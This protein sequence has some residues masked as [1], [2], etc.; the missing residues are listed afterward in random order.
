MKLRLGSLRAVPHDR[1]H[2]NA[3][4]RALSPG[5]HSM[6]RPLRTPPKRHGEHRST[7]PGPQRIPFIAIS[8]VYQR[9]LPNHRNS[10]RHLIGHAQIMTI[11]DPLSPI[12][13]VEQ[14]IRR[15]Y[16]RLGF[17]LPFAELRAHAVAA[18]APIN[19]SLMLAHL[20]ELNPSFF[21]TR[22]H[23]KQIQLGPRRAQQ[24]RR[25][26]ELLAELERALIHCMAAKKPL[27][28]PLANLLSEAL[29]C[30]DV[31]DA[32]A[33]R[34]VQEEGAAKRHCVRGGYLR[35]RDYRRVQRLT[36]RFLRTKAPAGRWRSKKH[37]AYTIAEHLGPLVTKH[38]LKI[39]PVEETLA[40]NV[41]KLMRRVPGAADA[42]ERHRRPHPSN[43]SSHHSR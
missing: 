36:L 17:R 26:A 38:D 15:R 25:T 18:V 41:L 29:G 7:D 34:H 42:F 16:E 11:L 39:S 14:E 19:S 37:A 4:I 22:I 40:H 33:A 2:R 5:Q 6:S 31:H 30:C 24:A 35:H 23:P 21:E 27:P 9:G 10:Q 8:D 20:A 12:H 1:T 43:R 28:K 13:A 32:H 3:L